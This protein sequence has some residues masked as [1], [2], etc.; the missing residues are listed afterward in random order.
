MDYI[1][2]SIRKQPQD[3]TAK[4]ERSPNLHEDKLRTTQILLAHTS[5]NYAR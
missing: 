2:S 4:Q 5:I 1:P 3:K